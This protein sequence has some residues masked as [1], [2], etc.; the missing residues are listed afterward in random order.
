[1]LVYNPGPLAPGPDRNPDL[2]LNAALY[3]GLRQ[4]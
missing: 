1:V 3:G 2:P 4:T